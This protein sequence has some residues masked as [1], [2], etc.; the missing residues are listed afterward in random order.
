[1]D[2]YDVIIAGCG[3]VGAAAANL[4]GHHGI[5]TLVIEKDREPYLLPRAIHFDHEIMRI[6]QSAGMAEELLPHLT[7]PAGAMFFGADRRVISQFRANVRTNRLGWASSYNFYQPDLERVLRDGLARRPSVRLIGGQSIEE[8]SQDDHGVRVVAR[9]DGG[10]IEARASYLLACDGGRSTVRKQIGVELTDLDFDEPWIVVD[11]FVDGPLDLPEL[12]GTPD[13][14][15]MQD[16]LFILGDPTRP[17]SVIPGVGKHR[18]FEFMLLPHEDPNDYDDRARVSALIEPFVKDRPHEI[19]RCAVYRFHA[20][21]A[22]RWQVGRVFLVGDAAHQTP[23]FFG[24]GMCHG[25]RDAA[26]L[27]WKLKLVLDGAAAPAL[28]DSYQ[29]ERLPQVRK[30]VEAS[31][32]AGQNLC[33]LDPARAAR[34]DEEMGAVAARVAPGYVEIIPAITGGVTGP[35]RDGVGARFIQ[36]PVATPDGRAGLLDDVTGGGFVLI[37][38]DR[39]LFDAAGALPTAVAAVGLRAFHLAGLDADRDAGTALLD[40]TGELQSWFDAR[41]CAGV[42]VRPDAYVHG[43]FGDVGELRELL[44][45]LAAQLA[46]GDRVCT[47][48]LAAALPD[49]LPA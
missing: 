33:T 38:R 27:A 23:P 20:L 18:R 11:T 13:G 2:R 46:P 1:M 21:L 4:L 35:A 16:V 32:R 26:N 3:P 12:Q 25:V 15:D 36:P 43:V 6:F 8:V 28:L 30:V 40:T 14:V 17:T 19:I 41:Q 29:P 22:E 37:C 10:T 34:R 7:T 24:Q 45:T 49:V 5:S 42:I 44:A 31:V 47:G 9:G 39:T 48:A